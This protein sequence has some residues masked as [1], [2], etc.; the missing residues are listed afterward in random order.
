MEKAKYGV[1][2]QVHSTD[3]QST[4]VV[5]A[6]VFFED[7]CS[8][9]ELPNDNDLIKDTIYGL[10]SLIRRVEEDDPELIGKVMTETIKALEHLYTNPNMTS[11]SNEKLERYFNTGDK[12]RTEETTGDDCIGGNFMD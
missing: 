12:S 8:E 1:L 11:L 5:V 7:Q 10:S 4:G 9:E 2:I 6:P 3:K